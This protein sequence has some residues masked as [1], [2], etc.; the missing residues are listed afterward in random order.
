MSVSHSQ[1]SLA[2][3]PYE[4]RV[5]VVE[6]H[7]AIQYAPCALIRHRGYSVIEARTAWDALTAAY[8]L[9]PH[10][11]FAIWARLTCSVLTWLV[12]CARSRVP[13]R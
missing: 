9:Q 13:S 2:S 4:V 8:R 3:S 5:P 6:D 1:S 11:A 12:V 7:E 10:C